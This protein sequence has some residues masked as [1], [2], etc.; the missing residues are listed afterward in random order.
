MRRIAGSIVAATVAVLAMVVGGSDSSAAAPPAAAALSHRSSVIEIRGA[1]ATPLHLSL[2]E[3]AVYPRTTLPL[4][5][6]VGAPGSVT[7][8]SVVEVISAAGPQF[9]AGKNPS[10]RAAVEVVGSLGRR[11]RFAYGE[12]DQGFGDHPALLVATD[13]RVDLVVPGDRTRLRSVIDVRSIELRVLPTEISTPPPGAV[14]ITD[15]RRSVTL[16]A[17]TLSRL[18]ATTRT[19]EFTAGGV[20]QQHTETGPSLALVQLV[21]G[22]VPAP[23][24]P[25]TATGAD[26]Y[27]AVVTNGEALLGGR[28]LLLGLVEDGVVLDRPR[29]VVDGDL[30]GGRYISEVVTLALSR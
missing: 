14:R 29:L 16:D 20:P 13:S 10:T 15:G 23:S 6:L 8:T 28:P 4:Q 9:G 3:L 5:H 17:R 19:V 30:K 27:G 11:V 2:D 7:G 12:F 18:P 26:G 1:V 24:T 22:F 21:A 25:V